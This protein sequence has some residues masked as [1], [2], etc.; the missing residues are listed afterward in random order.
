MAVATLESIRDRCYTLIEAL[1]P[2]SLSRDR[3]R[4][5]RDE[6]DG[7]FPDWAEA[8]TPGAFRRFQVREVGDDNPPD[9]SDTTMER[10]QATLEIT[11]A[12][13]QTARTGPANAMDR[14]DVQNQDWKLINAAVGLYG[15]GNFSGSNDCTPLGCVKSVE[16]VGKVDLLVVRMSVEYVRSLT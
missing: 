8:N 16:R 15:R 12:Y 1:V 13:P 11:V 10:V 7:N 6:G 5:Y 2:T 9:V 3:F 14:D 4:R